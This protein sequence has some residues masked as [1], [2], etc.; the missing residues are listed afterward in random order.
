MDDV[1][2]YNSHKCVIYQ[3]GNKEGTNLVR[4]G[5]KGLNIILDY[6]K[7]SSNQS[8]EAYLQTCEHA[9]PNVNVVVHGVC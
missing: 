1:I 9:T 4:V 5:E 3:Q 8:L 6:C 2:T 7:R